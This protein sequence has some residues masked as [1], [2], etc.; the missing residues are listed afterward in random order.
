MQAEGITIEA[1]TPQNEPLHDGNNPSMVMQP[2][3]QT[4]FI[5]NNLGPQ[6]KSAGLTTKIIAYDHNA[7]RVDYPK[8][9]LADPIGNAY[10]DGSAF[11]LY[12]GDINAL[13]EVHN[14]Y[15][16]KNIYFTEQYVGGPG[17]FGGDFNWHVKNLI[18]GATRNWSRTVLEW[19]LASDPAYM[20]H[21]VGGCNNCQG[22]ITIADTLVIRNTSYYIIGQASKFV[23]PG[24]VRI[25]S[26]I[27]GEVQNVA[28]KNSD[29]S[30]VLIALNTGSAA[31]EFDV[32]WR[33]KTFTYTLPAGAA[34][35]F[36][37]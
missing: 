1:I 31:A 36:K 32:K 22:A 20:P 14:S 11:H 4:N 15:P 30:K 19:N 9:V 34:A 24:A 2:A 16:K 37:W 21:T 28:F 25:A 35:T 8:T 5:K 18:I 33:N 6:L 12:A 13:S 3:E 17:N 10:V 27:A 26:N 7:D 29:G 23:K